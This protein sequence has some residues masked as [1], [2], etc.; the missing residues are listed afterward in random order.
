[1]RR[2]LATVALMCFAQGGLAGGLSLTAALDAARAYDPK[3]QSA[4]RDFEASREYGVYGRAALGPEVSLGASLAQNQL[5]Q[6]VGTAS[7]T[8]SYQSSNLLLQ[9]RQPLY[10]AELRARGR[11]GEARSRQGEA[12]LADQTSQLMVRLLEAYTNVPLAD[13]LLATATAEVAALGEQ[14]RSA[15]NMRA[16]GEGTVTDELEARSR[17]AVAEARLLEARDVREDAIGRLV[18]M[19]GPTVRPE[20]RKLD[21][22]FT[23][24]PLQPADLAAWELLALARNPTIEVR[25]HAL[26][27]AREVL[28]RSDAVWRPRLDAVASVSRADSDSINTVNQS[29]FQRSVGVQ[30]NMPVFDNGRNAS[31]ARQAAAAMGSA[32]A[33][34]DDA[35][36]TVL[37]ELRKQYRVLL[38]QAQKVSA[39]S[40]ALDAATL[41]VQATRQSV[42]GGIRVTLDVLNAQTQRFTVQQELTQARFNYFK[43]WFRLRAAAGVLDVSDL[44]LIDQQL[45]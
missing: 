20:P 17:L 26:Q 29:S 24:L 41:Q 33:M 8:T 19:L 16:R 34:L 21:A 4:L 14:L 1:M 37:T 40:E 15:Q 6:S 7:R 9:L 3:Y 42:K 10:N 38:S 13:E 18:M 25:R 11:E 2:T 31:Q 45:K 28:D 12:A 30:L 36:E 5:D 43:A 23:R 35:R 44:L 22:M 32:Q 39:Y 27:A